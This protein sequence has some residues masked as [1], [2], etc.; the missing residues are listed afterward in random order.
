MD[1][2]RF[3]ELALSDMT[4]ECCCALDVDFSIAK[5]PVMLDCLH[6]CGIKNKS[7]DTRTLQDNLSHSYLDVKPSELYYD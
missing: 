7:K 2:S 3:V 1:T 6:L 4:R 5:I